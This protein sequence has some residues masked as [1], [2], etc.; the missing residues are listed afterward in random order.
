MARTDAIVLGA[1]IV[2]TSAALH[3]AK[4]G[5]A[6]ALVDRAGPGEQTS[7]G[8]AGIIEG[9]TIFPHAFPMDFGSLLRIAL[10]RAPEANYHLS[11]LP[12][13]A[14]WLLAYRANT[15][16]GRSL[17]FAEAMR[18][19]FSH[20]VSEH[21]A[22]M[23][24][25]GASRYLRKEGW[26]KLYRHDASFENTRRERE[27]AE[28]FGLVAQ[29]LG[30]DDTRALEPSLAPVFRHAV[31]WKDAASVTNPL[32]VT[33]AYAARFTKLGGVIL[34]GDARTLHRSGDV[35]RVDTDE[36]PVDAKDAVVALG[37]W[38]PDVLGPLGIR[39]PLA[40]KRGYHRHFQPRGNAGLTRPIVD[41]DVGYCLAPM[42]QGI[43]I[44]TGA[45]FA[46][47]DAAPTPAQFDRL[48]PSARE[49]FPL[50]QEVEQKPWMGSRPCFADSRPVIG[51][52]P[53]QPGLWLDYGH[54]HWG[55]TLG[56]ASGRLLAEMMTGAM[57][58]CDPAPYS[59][60]RFAA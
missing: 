33:K 54:A 42:E 57:P 13:V 52:A 8:N 19:L 18:P 38:G 7:Y 47:R 46:D 39:L 24:E 31:H 28:K 1:G 48:M 58:F 49:L 32:A 23:A 15:Q 25:A 26:L 35:W 37:P 30:V 10:K 3:L 51:H 4:R 22:L 34:K 50:G 16:V 12:K 11:F 44:T 14:T 45:E 43:R 20:A 2:G 21:E 6:V 40:V 55:L 9:N 60:E 5:L 27:L 36:G 53:G 41:A 56:P 17:V 59:A 29:P